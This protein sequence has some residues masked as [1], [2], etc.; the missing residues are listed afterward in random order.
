MTPRVQYLICAVLMLSYSLFWLATWYGTNL[1]AVKESFDYPVPLFSGW[2]LDKPR[3]NRLVCLA[4]SGCWLTTNINLDGSKDTC[5]PTT[6][7][8]F[9]QDIQTK[10]AKRL[11]IPAFTGAQKGRG[12]KSAP[13]GSTKGDARTCIFV[14]KDE[15]LADACLFSSTDPLDTLTVT[16]KTQNTPVNFGVA[17][18]TEK[19]FCDRS[20]TQVCEQDESTVIGDDGDSSADTTLSGIQSWAQRGFKFRTIGG[21][22]G[23]QVQ[24]LPYQLHYGEIELRP[25]TSKFELMNSGNLTTEF[26]PNYLSTDGDADSSN[27]CYRNTNAPGPSGDRPQCED[28]GPGAGAGT[29]KQLKIRPS[30]IA[31]FESR[32]IATPF[33][34]FVGAAG[35]VLSLLIVSMRSMHKGLRFLLGNR[36]RACFGN[37]DIDGTTAAVV[38][39]DTQESIDVTAS[40]A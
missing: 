28:G 14:A 22:V 16:W 34:A 40:R 8:K 25:R 21:G 31:S 17:L 38:K 20:T 30:A 19:P 12:G 18:V 29:C 32:S 3:G 10:L 35:G 23:Y 37:P 6:L 11:N 1:G 24:Q 9:D 4:E 7:G 36:C 33:W 27:M 5:P 15:V 26:V 39:L 2:R 13:K